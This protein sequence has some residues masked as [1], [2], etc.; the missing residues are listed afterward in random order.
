MECEYSE[1]LQQ[2]LCESLES[3][4]RSH[5]LNFA[6]RRNEQALPEKIRAAFNAYNWTY[7]LAE[8]IGSIKDKGFFEESE[9]RLNC[10]QPR[11]MA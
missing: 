1:G 6:Q 8:L 2:E 7:K 9:S 10:P 4:F 5:A 3:D 11:A